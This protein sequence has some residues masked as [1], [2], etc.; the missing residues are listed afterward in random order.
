MSACTTTSQNGR[1]IA[2]YLSDEA[3]PA[4]QWTLVAGLQEK[5]I[6]FNVEE[7]DNTTD[8]SNGWVRYDCLGGNK[9]IEISV[10]GIYTDKMFTNIFWSSAHCRKFKLQYQ[11]G[12]ILT[13]CWSV[14][15]YELKANNKENVKFSA[16]LKS[17]GEIVRT[18]PV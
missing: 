2:L 6:K 16:T 13:G 4:E 7:I 8:D 1:N 9:S 5:N 14:N 3:T 17:S 15:D 12:E 10:S 18:L 11:D